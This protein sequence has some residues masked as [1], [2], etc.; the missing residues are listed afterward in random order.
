MEISGRR[1]A[2]ALLLPVALAIVTIGIS[3]ALGALVLGSPDAFFGASAASFALLGIAAVLRAGGVV[4]LGLVKFGGVSLREV[5]WREQSPLLAIALGVAGFAGIAAALAGIL[6]A[7]G[8]LDLGAAAHTIA[9]WSAAQRALFLCIAVE[10][11]FTEETIFR[12][13][14]QPALASRLGLAGGIL[15]Q[16]VVFSLYHVPRGPI[17][18]LTRFAFGLVLGVLRGRDRPLW[19]CAIAHALTWIVLGSL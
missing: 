1:L 12:G 6:A 17:P 18:L 10:A 7:F 15:A 11:G 2:H 3:G 8:A 14:L 19:S 16:A 4:G 9:T 5:G 13:F